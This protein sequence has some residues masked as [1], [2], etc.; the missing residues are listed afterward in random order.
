MGE[1]ALWPVIGV[2]T[3]ANGRLLIA[4]QEKPHNR[5]LA[6]K[7]A[8]T[9]GQENTL[10]NTGLEGEVLSGAFAN[11]R[12]EGLTYRLVGKILYLFLL[13]HGA[14]NPRAGWSLGIN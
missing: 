4:L 12:G 9:R 8:G 7:A 1:L 11:G 10:A 5:A 6:S 14:Y 2:L 3:R 13:L